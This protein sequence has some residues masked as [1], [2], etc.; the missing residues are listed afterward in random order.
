MRKRLIFMLLEGLLPI[1]IQVGVK[2][3]KKLTNPKKLSEDDVKKA[4][5][6]AKVLEESAKKISEAKKKVKE[7]TEKEEKS[8]RSLLH[9]IKVASKSARDF[10]QS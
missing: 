4:E 7:K 8:K 5:D 9:R 1:L 10:N 6:G 2:L 3:V